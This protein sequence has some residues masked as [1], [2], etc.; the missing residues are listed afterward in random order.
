[1]ALVVNSAAKHKSTAWAFE[2]VVFQIP[3]LHKALL[4]QAVQKGYLFKESNSIRF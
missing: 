1:V 2:K 4:R 3:L